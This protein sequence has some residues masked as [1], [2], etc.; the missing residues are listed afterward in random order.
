MQIPVV[1]YVLNREQLNP[2][3]KVSDDKL[4]EN[5]IDE[6]HEELNLQAGT[7]TAPSLKR[8]KHFFRLYKEMF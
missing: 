2:F 6:L 8:E 1:V 4:F 7:E 5:G 3:L